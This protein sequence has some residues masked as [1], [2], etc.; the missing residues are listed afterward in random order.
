MGCPGK[1]RGRTRALSA[2]SRRLPQASGMTAGSKNG[3]PAN[4]TFV[5]CPAGAYLGPGSEHRRRELPLLRLRSAPSLP[6][7]SGNL[8]GRLCPAAA[9]PYRTSAS[10]R[11]VTAGLTGNFPARLCPAA[12]SAPVAAAGVP[13][14]A[15]GVPQPV[16]P[17]AQI[18]ALPPSAAPGVPVAVA[19]MTVIAP[20]MPQPVT[21][22]AQIPTLPP[23]AAPAVLLFVTPASHAL[24]QQR[25]SVAC[26]PRNGTQGTFSANIVAYVPLLGTQGTPATFKKAWGSVS[27]DITPPIFTLVGCLTGP[28]RISHS[29][30]VSTGSSGF[31]PSG[32]AFCKQ[33]G[34]NASRFG[35]LAE[36]P[37]GVR[38]DSRLTPVRISSQ[39]ASIVVASCRCKL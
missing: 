30:G 11:P 39:A 34:P 36:V 17:A 2:S 29:W 38:Q 5:G 12:A 3:V 35:E 33:R 14:T 6:A 24:T 16:T 8:P 27:T 31:L 15:A 4:F 37:S 21:P 1:Q 19:G 9:S 25:A 28:L 32:E 10:A 20:G 18:P 7:S 26:V 22:A 13:I 23:S